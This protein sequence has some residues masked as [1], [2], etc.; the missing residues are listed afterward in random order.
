MILLLVFRRIGGLKVGKGGDIE[1]VDGRTDL[2]VA[3]L[4]WV[5]RLLAKVY[6]PLLLYAVAFFMVSLH[7]VPTDWFLASSALSNLCL[8][9]KT[10]AKVDCVD[11]V[12]R[13]LSRL[14]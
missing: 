12:R 3:L 8:D 5:P 6:V 4:A 9:A 7:A 11:D 10:M 13:W 14:P 1:I 2:L